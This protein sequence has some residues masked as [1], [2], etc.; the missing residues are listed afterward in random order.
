MLY[1]TEEDWNKNKIVYFVTS[2][3]LLKKLKAENNLACGT[4]KT[5]PKNLPAKLTED[6]KT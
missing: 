1:L 6:K 2:V 3:K 5:N 4:I